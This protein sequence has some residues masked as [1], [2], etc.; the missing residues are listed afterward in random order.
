MWLLVMM[1][2]YIRTYTLYCIYIGEIITRAQARE[3]D[4]KE[5]TTAM[6]CMLYI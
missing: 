6:V 5:K 4:F 1:N 2:T 3:R